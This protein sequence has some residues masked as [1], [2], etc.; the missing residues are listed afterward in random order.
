MKLP[1]LLRAVAALAETGGTKQQYTVLTSA[2]DNLVNMVDWA[3]GPIDPK[4]HWLSRLA[5]LQDD[6]QYRHA[7][8]NDP[9]IVLLNDALTKLGR[10]IAQHDADFEAGKAGDDEGE[11]FS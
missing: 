5:T 1:E 4:G 3:G 7:Q 8:R 9:A 10:A 6:L 11:D 2:A